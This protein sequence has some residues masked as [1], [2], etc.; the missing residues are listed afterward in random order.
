MGHVNDPA[1]L[2]AE[3]IADSAV[4]ALHGSAMAA[5]A[6]TAGLTPAST[7]PAEIGA[8]GGTL[9]A[10]VHSAITSARG[11]GTAL[12]GAVRRQMEDVLGSDFSG[13]RI[14]TGRVVDDVAARIAARAFTVGRD[15][16]FR[17]GLP[18]TSTPAGTHLLAHELAHVAQTHPSPLRPE[19]ER[20]LPAVAGVHRAA[21]TVRRNEES[22]ALLKDLATPKVFEGPEV[23]LQQGIVTQLEAKIPEMHKE[24]YAKRQAAEEELKKWYDE[25][26]KPEKKLS[27]PQ[28]KEITETKNQR[29]R[30]LPPIYDQPILYLGSVVLTD[31][32][33][34][35]EGDG[36]LIKNAELIETDHA[37][38]AKENAVELPKAAGVQHDIVRNTLRTMIAAGQMEYLR[39]SGFVG[40]G[41]KVVVEVHYYRSRARTAANLHKDTLG[42]TLFVNLNYTNQ[43]D[44]AGPEFLVNPPTVGTHEDKIKDTLPEE[45]RSDLKG[46]REGL[47]AGSA[48]TTKTLKPNSVV[49]FVDE[50]I[51]HATPLVGHRDIAVA[52]LGEFLQNDPEFK[53][54]YAMA[55]KAYETSLEEIGWLASWVKSKQS[56]AQAFTAP[57]SIEMKTTWERL[58]RLCLGDLKDKKTIKEKVQRPELLELGMTDEQIDRLLSEYGPDTFSAVNIPTRAR[59]NPQSSGRIPMIDPA[60]KRPP[61]LKRQMS[62]QALDKKLPPVSTA[63]RRLPH[64][65]ARRAHRADQRGERVLVHLA[66]S[67]RR[68]DRRD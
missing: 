30:Q 14:H 65:G 9:S 58:M 11:G 36:E 37:L 16:F 21:T 56:F 12:P 32:P 61:T 31:I 3:G 18:S 67:V 8:E 51:H 64:L 66:A 45:F 1:E 2:E 13:V 63:E 62:Q 42:Q 47:P 33:P 23:E 35:A 46:V 28:F 48:I 40:K 39:K 54:Q 38:D 27:T 4:A 20:A 5:S 34:T 25:A 49:A 57:V 29:L 17:G 24:A 43:E 52:K 44:D 41:W 19:R 60:T 6:T 68:H 26:T 53:D 59:T 10:E 7:A 22:T 55:K 50:A 15:V